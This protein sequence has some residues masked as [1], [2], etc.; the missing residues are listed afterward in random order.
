MKAILKIELKRAFCNK[1]FYCVVLVGCVMAMGVFFTSNAF[2]IAKLWNYDYLNNTDYGVMATSK[3]DFMD[4]ALYIWIGNKASNNVFSYLLAVIMPILTA[5]PYGATYL[6]DKKSGLINQILAR[7][8][9]RDY[10]FAK[11]ITAFVSGGTIA[12]IPVF[13]NLVICMCVLPFGTPIYSTHYFSVSSENVLGDL[14]YTRP[15]LYV[16]IYFLFSFV[17]AGLFN[18]LCVTFVYFVDNVFV[19]LLVPFIIYFS[20]HVIFSY[21]I[22]MGH[23]SLL[24]ASKLTYFY[25][26]GVV[27]VAVQLVILIVSGLSVLVRTKKD[28]I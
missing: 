25:K 22:N 27:A 5:I 3:L 11:L 4:I 14:F 2:D 17:V 6:N 20:L 8:K 21:C 16:I 26:D 28:V 15:V 23:S 7:V 10:Y 1:L 9:R 12:V 13:L 19:I 18:C 24:W